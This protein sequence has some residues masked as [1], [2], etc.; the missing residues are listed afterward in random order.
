[1][2]PPEINRSPE[3]QDAL[4]QLHKAYRS[5]RPK[6]SRRMRE[7]RKLRRAP[8]RRL[9]EELCF[10]LLTPQS[11]AV[12]CDSVIRDLRL[13]GLLLSGGEQELR[14][15]LKR[16]RFYR[17]KASYLVLAREVFLSKDKRDLK[18]QDP[19]AL[20]DWLVANIK[21]LGLKEAGHFLRNIGLGEDL[22]ILDIH[23]LRR[24][25]TLKVIEEI[26]SNLSR[27]KYLEIEEKMRTFSRQCGIP[28]G[29]MD[30]LFWCMG[31]GFVFK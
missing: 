5:H 28:L 8:K 6:I 30:L 2:I 12:S 22:A 25:K 3:F 16:A 31:T 9:F 14:P 10:C 24:L 1:M 21:G 17:K 4:K 29:H 27:K 19:R 13:A 23:I 18:K 7:F 20:R 11:N 15:F 26:P